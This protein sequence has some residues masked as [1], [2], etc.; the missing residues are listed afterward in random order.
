MKA[1]VVY[2]YDSLALAREV[3]AFLEDN[4]VHAELF[5]LPSS[6]LG[7]YDLI[8]SVGGDGT[9]LQILQ[10]LKKCPPIFG[11]N[12]GKIGLLTHSEPGNFREVLKN[13][14]EGKCRT[15]SFMRIDG[16]INGETRMR[17]LNE[18]AILS[19]TPARLIGLRVF[20]DGV[21]IEDMRSDGMLFSTPIG[22]T[23]YALATGGPV[24]DPY[25][26]SILITPI[27]PFKL[28]WKPWIVSAKSRINV[29]LHPE[30]KALI[31][32]DG[33]KT[34]EVSPGDK[35]EIVKSN[36]PAVFFESPVKRIKRI[37]ERLR[38]IR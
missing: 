34:I 29:E 1:G 8:V 2:K 35:I 6:E 32:S 36:Y 17:A 23:A 13:V 12:R 16:I 7:K 24:V 4:G 25:L 27:A 26:P 28:G 11:I 14:L 22:S 3:A 31:I 10:D 15:E 37:A 30:R 9:I 20:V 19:S 5:H 18:I 33:Q 21:E 38:N